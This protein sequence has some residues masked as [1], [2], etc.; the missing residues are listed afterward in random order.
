[1]AEH[2]EAGLV[3]PDH[4]EAVPEE[5]PVVVPEAGLARPDHLEV[6]PEEHQAVVLEERPEADLVLGL[7]PP[8]PRGF[9]GEAEQG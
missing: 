2:P 5:H 8:A 6:V 3:R 1:V 9:Q 4:L 7:V